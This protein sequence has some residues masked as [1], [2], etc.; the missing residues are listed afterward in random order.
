MSRRFDPLSGDVVP[1]FFHYA[2]PSVIGILAA[3]LKLLRSVNTF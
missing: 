1:V 3:T 2:V